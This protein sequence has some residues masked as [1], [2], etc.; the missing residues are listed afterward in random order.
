METN[1]TGQ[2]EREEGRQSKLLQIK[3][4]FVHAAITVGY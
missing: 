3:I 2:P 4:I 1:R